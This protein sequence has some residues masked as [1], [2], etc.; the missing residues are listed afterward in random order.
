MKEKEI[1]VLNA[2]K[3]TGNTGWGVETDHKD[4]PLNVVFPVL[5]VEV[6]PDKFLWVWFKDE[7]DWEDFLRFIPSPDCQADNRFRSLDDDGIIAIWDIT[8]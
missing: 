2:I 6:C 5:S 8:E 4:I 1:A 3:V 7:C